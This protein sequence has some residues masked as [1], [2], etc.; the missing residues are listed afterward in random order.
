MTT[1]VAAPPKASEPGRTLDDPQPR[2]LGFLDQTAL[3]GNLGIS[4]LGPVTAVYV[5][6]PGMSFL[7]AFTA[8]VVGTLI[9][10]GGLALAN[11][12]GAQT[13]KPAMVLLRGLFGAR[14]SY[15]PTVL[16]VVQVL[17]WAI[18]EIVVISQAASQLLPWHA[19]WPYILV[20]GVL[21]TV[22]AIRPLG[23]VRL[24]RRYALVAVLA[25]MA[26]LVI[27]LFR[28][29]LPS[30][31]H[32]SWNGFWIGTDLVIA[33]SV[34]W[35]PLAAD[36]SRHSR[37]PGAAF[38]GSIIGYGLTQILCYGLG[39]LALATVASA[40]PTQHGMFGAFIAVPVGWLAFGVLLLRELDESF[41][42]VYSTA[43]STQNLR[44]L[45]DRR[46]LAIVIGTLATA[47]AFWLDH[48]SFQAAYQN[49]LS[50]IGSIFIPMFAVFV[51]RYFLLRDGR[52]WDTSENAP[53]RWVLLVPWVLGFIAYQLV[54]PGLVTTWAHL[55]THARGWLHFTPESWMSASIISFL[56]AGI[57]TLALAST[58]RRH[59]R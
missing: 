25:A 9:G 35:I 3:W 38:G 36:Y 10:V 11:V 55:W 6:A 21:T 37:T 42:N 40:D 7:A 48:S 34:S 12:A 39:L 26:Y 30:F 24:L 4:L 49:F 29:P 15:L 51:V 19:H 46:V 13:G 59:A 5:V 2:T 41:A 47:G 16:N 57:V 54:N 28:E 56:V 52:S 14:L 23:A 18:F 43:V 32:G 8:V 31:T 44:P 50:L 58:T 53:S 45:W 27:Q 33:V 20:A 1:L 17:G 22:M